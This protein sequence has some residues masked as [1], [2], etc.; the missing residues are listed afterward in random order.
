MGLECWTLHQLD[1]HMISLTRP[2]R[3]EI[4]LYHELPYG[5]G[6]PSL[7]IFFHFLL[8]FL[9]SFSSFHLQIHKQQLLSINN[10]LSLQKLF[11]CQFRIVYTKFPVKKENSTNREKK[12][13]NKKLKKGIEN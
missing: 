13:K 8:L 10:R 3:H 11:F 9:C 12:F 5:G 4:K 2:P 7:I 1:L 6:S